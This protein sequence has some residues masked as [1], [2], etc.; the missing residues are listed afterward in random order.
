MRQFKLKIIL[1]GFLAFFLVLGALISIWWIRKLTSPSEVLDRLPTIVAG[2]G[3]TVITTIVN[4]SLRWI[5]WHFLAR[6]VGAR[7]TVKDSLLIYL[8]T[9]PAIL[10]PFY[11]GEL[12][13]AIL[14]GRKYPRH[15]TEMIYVW[16]LERSSDFL[17]LSLFAAVN[18]RFGK[19][20][21]IFTLV[22]IVLIAVMRFRFRLK[23]FRN[24]P[25]AFVVMVVLCSS[26][27]A[28]LPIGIALWGNLYMM[29]DS[30]LSF[31]NTLS[32]FAYT[33]VL[34]GI[35]AIP[36]GIGVTG[37]LLVR[38]LT[39]Q[40]VPLSCAILCTVVFRMGTVYF[41][42][43]VGTLTIIFKWKKLLGQLQTQRIEGHFD[44]IAETYQQRIPEHVRQRLLIRKVQY[45]KE[46]LESM[47]SQGTK[48]GLDIGC[49]HGWY[50]CEMAKSG[51]Q[52]CGIDKSLPQIQMAR[53]YAKQQNINSHFFHADAAK[54][55]FEDSYFDFA[56]AINVL[57]HIVNYDVQLQ[58]FREI[59]RIL[60]PGGVFFLQE[61]NTINPLF[62]FYL[63][64]VFPLIR[65]I[66]E[67]NE[68]WIRP[69]DLPDLSGA[70]WVKNKLYFTFLPD[71][72]P[73]FLL[74]HLSELERYLEKSQL[75][76]GSAHYI[77]KLLKENR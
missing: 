61:V 44:D 15:R 34:G 62:R 7:L 76:K 33:T 19:H 28:W 11:I 3:L 52:M 10:T 17:V 22:W 57:H 74:K 38:Q 60:K 36:V 55:P 72:I 23:N 26:V 12:L 69:N 40:A 25:S 6:S 39:A 67:G 30:P 27:L 41:I 65:G 70:Y 48:L 2:L 46:T 64:Y 49:G 51:Y 29:M 45:M 21:I 47:E 50:T 43:S 1:C 63:G 4:I 66:D 32:A 18:G 58:V 5:R 8:V 20:L 68:R 9:L 42:V 16:L 13:R 14:V 35:T 37:S 77:A 59:V 54:L 24:W 73:G 75:K 56:Y 53:Q 71:F 31:V